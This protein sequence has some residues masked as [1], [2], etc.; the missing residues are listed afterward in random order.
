MSATLHFPKALEIHVVDAADQRL[1]PRIGLMLTIFSPR[2]N[3]YHLAKVTN[4]EGKVRITDAEMRE[5]IRTDQELFPMD[6]ASL[7]EECSAEIEVKVCTADEIKRAVIAMEMFKSVTKI[8]DALLYGFQ[9][10]RNAEYVA[11]S[12]RLTLDE[13]MD[14]VM[15]K[16]V[17]QK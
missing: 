3:H 17:I 8:D 13:T 5:S 4:V 15:V 9:T 10:S 12:Q 6:Y 14:E 1:V 16:I 11:T 2:K 7:L